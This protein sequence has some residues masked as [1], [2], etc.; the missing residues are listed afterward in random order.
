MSQYYCHIVVI[1]INPISFVTNNMVYRKFLDFWRRSY[2][3]ISSLS[4]DEIN[5]S[6]KCLEDYFR[7][8]AKK[9][10]IYLKEL[11]LTRNRDQ[12][13]PLE[14]K[15]YDILSSVPSE[16]ESFYAIHI[17]D[18]RFL[19]ACYLEQLKRPDIWGK[20]CPLHESIWEKQEDRFAW[21]ITFLS[22]IMNKPRTDQSMYQI[23]ILDLLGDITIAGKN[24]LD[25]G[26]DIGISSFDF[27]KRGANVT[28][29]EPDPFRLAGDGTRISDVPEAAGL[30][31]YHLFYNHVYS[32]PLHNFTYIKSMI[33]ECQTEQRF[34]SAYFFFP[35]PALIYDSARDSHK[36]MPEIVDHTLGLLKEKGTLTFVTEASRPVLILGKKLDV[37]CINGPN[38]TMG[39]RGSITGSTTAVSGEMLNYN[40]K[41]ITYTK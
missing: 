35:D 28:V 36:F 10:S 11:N 13:N 14:Q 23:E 39:L 17:K 24:I 6:S 38:G 7:A 4:E 22:S 41:I 16:K 3:Q 12:F 29:V 2:P 19:E 15:I 31:L 8:S 33:E 37:K 26:S 40:L 9:D 18:I 27:V 32:E 25:I 34:D 20:P 30:Q 1:I 21:D 5:A